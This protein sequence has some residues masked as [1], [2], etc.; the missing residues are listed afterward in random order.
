MHINKVLS[1]NPKK[2][3]KEIIESTKSFIGYVNY[4]L[5]QVD[6][7]VDG[8]YGILFYDCYAITKNRSPGRHFNKEEILK[9][10]AANLIAPA[11]NSAFHLLLSLYK[12]SKNNIHIPSF[13]V[14]YSLYYSF[15]IKYRDNEIMNPK[16]LFVGLFNSLNELHE[17]DPKKSNILFKKITRFM[18]D[19]SDSSKERAQKFISI[20]KELRQYWP[21]IDY[22]IVS[23]DR[24]IDNFVWH[25]EFATNFIREDFF[26]DTSTI[27]NLIVAEGSPVTIIEDHGNYL[28][29]QNQAVGARR[30]H[31]SK[32]NLFF[33]Q[34]QDQILSHKPVSCIFCDVGGCAKIVSP[35][36]RRMLHKVTTQINESIHLFAM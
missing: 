20:A 30:I 23:P 11:S 16:K 32:M 29:Y 9:A 12:I 2:I 15:F 34:I 22:L 27:G 21:D 7:I 6:P 25:R 35:P 17:R 14:H 13:V 26:N 3:D 4:L 24:I 1:S 18:R 5:K 28:I 19:K 31:N 10:T 33:S 8:H 36:Y